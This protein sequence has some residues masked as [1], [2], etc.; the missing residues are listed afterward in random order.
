MSEPAESEP[1]PLA[2]NTS[3]SATSAA[4]KPGTAAPDAAAIR[5]RQRRHVL[6]SGWLLVALCVAWEGWLAPLRPGG[7]LLMLKVAPLLILLPGMARGLPRAYQWTTL[8]ILLY[9]CE[10]VVRAA[11]ES[12]PVR[13]LAVLELMLALT[14]YVC[15]IL[16][17]RAG[18]PSRSRR[19]KRDDEAQ[20]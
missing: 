8:L 13:D 12:S 20:R 17:L 6:L 11:S 7:S 3:D 18:R 5:A 14:V 15:A 9:V 10:G 19:R 16:W 1:R 4:P 2:P